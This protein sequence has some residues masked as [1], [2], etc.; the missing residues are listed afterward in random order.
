VFPDHGFEYGL[1][2][3]KRAPDK[4]GAHWVVGWKKLPEISGQL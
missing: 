1:K 2:K 3:K 4:G